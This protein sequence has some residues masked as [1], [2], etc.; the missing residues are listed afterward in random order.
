MQRPRPHGGATPQQVVMGEDD[1][2]LPA[3]TL[4]SPPHPAGL[5][6]A[7]WEPLEP[8]WSPPLGSLP[9]SHPVEQG[10]RLHLPRPDEPSLVE[11]LPLHGPTLDAPSGQGAPTSA[12]PS[13]S[14][15]IWLPGPVSA[16]AIH[17]LSLQMASLDLC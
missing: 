14:S 6:P 15:S 2:P 7:G 13:S 8:W 5:E 16:S 3:H 12:A 17:G 1:C 4:P 10:R 11:V 9:S